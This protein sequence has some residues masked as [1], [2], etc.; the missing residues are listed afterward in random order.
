MKHLSP[1]ATTFPSVPTSISAPRPP[2]VSR[3][4]KAPLPVTASYVVVQAISLLSANVVS[5]PVG[6]GE[7]GQFREHVRHERLLACWL[8]TLAGL[9]RSEVLGLRWSDVDLDAGTVS[10]AQG[11]VVV[12]G[13]GTATGD[14]KSKRSRR[15]LP[16]PA[17]VLTALRAFKVQQ[18]SERLAL[19]ERYPDTGF[20]SVNEDGSPSGRRPTRP[21]SPGWRKPL[22]YPRFGYT[23]SGTPPPP[24]SS[25]AAPHRRRRPSGWVTTRRSRYGCMGTSTTTRWRRRATRYSAGRG[26]TKIGDLVFT[27]TPNGSHFSIR[28]SKS[29]HMSAWL[30]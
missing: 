2:G 22:A 28:E 23:M 11:R 9:R 3:S 26:P 13:Q 17:D 6:R 29:A 14:P 4:Q 19:G 7:A 20:V 30:C 12:A 8:L 10:V 16:M 24:R 1:E 25:T 15:A 18:A 27:V 21:N 5:D